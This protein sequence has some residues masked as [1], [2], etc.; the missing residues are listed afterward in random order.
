MT[1]KGD[2]WATINALGAPETTRVT[3]FDKGY[4]EA[5]KDVL[6]IIEALEVDED[7][8]DQFSRDAAE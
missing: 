6:A 1:T 4:C 8:P 7:A 2:L 3:D 5:I